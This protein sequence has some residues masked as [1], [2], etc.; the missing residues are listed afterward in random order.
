MGAVLAVNSYGAIEQVQYLLTAWVNYR[1][2]WKPDNGLPHAVCWIDEV[3]GSI[4]GWTDGEDYDNRIYATEM[5]HV[6]EAI[7]TLASEYQHAIYVVYLN[8]IGPAVWRSGK[9]AMAE[10]R[11]LC[12]VAE[13][14]LVPLLKRRNVVF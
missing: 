9:K 4:D 12:D 7:R 11:T 6:D 13:R 10:I 8:E 1:K 3:R 14:Q 2:R 5:R